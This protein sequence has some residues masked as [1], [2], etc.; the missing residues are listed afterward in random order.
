[1][2]TST[3]TLFLL[4]L[5]ITAFPTPQLAVAQAPTSERA[6]LYLE[7]GEQRLLDLPGLMKYSVSGNAVHY[8]RIENKNQILLKAVKAGTATLSVISHDVGTTQTRIIRVEQKKSLTRPGNLLQALNRLNRTEVIDEG[9]R[10]VL[11]GRVKDLSEAR[12]ISEISEHFSQYVSNETEIDPTWLQQNIRELSRIV[13]AYPALTLSEEEGTL[14]LRG[15]LTNAALAQAVIHKVRAIQPLTQIEIQTLKDSNPTIYFKVFLLE[16]KKELISSIGTQWADPNAATFQVSPAKF[17]MGNSIDLSIHTLSQKGMVRI[18]SAP[19]LVV[20]APGQ[21]ELFAGGELPIR[22]VSKFAESV[23]WKNF[24]LSLK[25]D[26]KEFGG[27]KVR[28]EIATE[29]SQLDEAR[30]NDQIPVIQTN[31]LKTY[32]EATM[33]KPLL[34]SGLLQEGLKEKV[35]GL[36]WL[37]HLPVLGKLFGSE[38]YQKDRSE[39]V[40][41]L[42]PHR[43][44]PPNPQLRISSDLPKGFL[45]IPR[46]PLNSEEK[47]ELKSNRHYPW[48]IL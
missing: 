40:A 32:V 21:A 8:L 6:P 1:M 13:S 11:H 12:A 43:E 20:R 27:E 19:E 10:F 23:I 31:K 22:Q 17:I 28:L 24:G 16:V 36:P 29:M 39:L 41:V 45:P 37:A 30:T 33:G 25:L 46:T 9:D 18:L 35:S 44:P 47:E 34:L 14:S 15:G 26:V 4:L 3:F 48:N 2:K 5:L 7:I 38:D 42:L